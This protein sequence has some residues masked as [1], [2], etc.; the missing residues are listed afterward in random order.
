MEKY[1]SK[2]NF[3]I[4]I[5]IKKPQWYIKKHLMVHCKNGKKHLM[6]HCKNGTWKNC[7]EKYNFHF[8]KNQLMQKMLILNI[9]ETNILLEIKALSILWTIKIMIK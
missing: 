6:V 1:E 3:Y 7:I 8:Q 5:H 4:L 2:I 9:Y